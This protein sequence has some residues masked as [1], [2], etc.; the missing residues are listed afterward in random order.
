MM[1]AIEQVSWCCDHG[2]QNGW[3]I[4]RLGVLQ[5]DTNWT[6]MFQIFAENVAKTESWHTMLEGMLAV[7]GFPPEERPRAWVQCTQLLV[8]AINLVDIDVPALP[9]K[10]ICTHL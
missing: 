3:I 7:L 6:Q 2:V 9:K 5:L 4:Q 1:R 10:S 8:T